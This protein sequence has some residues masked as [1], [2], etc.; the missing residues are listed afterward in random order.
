ML[1]YTTPCYVMQC[2]AYYSI[3]PLAPFSLPLGPEFSSF[4]RAAGFSRF[5]APLWRGFSVQKCKGPRP[6]KSD[7]PHIWFPPDPPRKLKTGDRRFKMRLARRF[8]KQSHR[9]GTNENFCKNDSNFQQT[10]L[11]GWRSRGPAMNV[12]LSGGPRG[13]AKKT[14]LLGNGQP[15]HPGP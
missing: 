7:L 1:Y 14:A 4:G 5:S 12:N 9:F 15:V 11:S 8:L 13:G 2:Y 3:A 6:G 10:N